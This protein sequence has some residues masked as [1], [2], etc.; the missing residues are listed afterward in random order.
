MSA[1]LLTISEAAK[2]GRL[3]ETLIRRACQ[4]GKISGAELIG[5][6]WVFTPAAFNE[7]VSTRNTKRGKPKGSSK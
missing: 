2:L 3:S 4:N 7:W 5:K 6:T 1:K